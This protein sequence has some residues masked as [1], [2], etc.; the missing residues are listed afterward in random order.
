MW[1]FVLH[2]RSV[3]YVCGYIRSKRHRG[4]HSIISITI[5]VRSFFQ[6]VLMTPAYPMGKVLDRIFTKLYGQRYSR[7]SD[8]IARTVHI[9][10]R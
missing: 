4:I 2:L 9:G 8:I 3:V 6:T 10:V 1:Q 5:H 7:Q